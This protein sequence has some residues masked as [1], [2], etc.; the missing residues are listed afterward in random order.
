MF[1]SLINNFE[2]PNLR[3]NKFS[4]SDNEFYVR[5][6]HIKMLMY[7]KVDSL[8]RGLYEGHFPHVS[9]TM[10]MKLLGPLKLIQSLDME[11]SN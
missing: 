4:T 6:T 7:L 11:I 3:I 2:F 9:I 10:T 8:C 5:D 1:W